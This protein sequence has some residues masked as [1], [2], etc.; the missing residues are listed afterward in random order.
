MRVKSEGSLAVRH[1]QNCQRFGL[2]C[3]VSK[4]EAEA[5]LRATSHVEFELSGSCF[6]PLLL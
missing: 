4:L 6:V 5:L 2:R 1:F 3:L